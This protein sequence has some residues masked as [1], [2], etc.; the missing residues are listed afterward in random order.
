MPLLLVLMLW[1]IEHRCG[2]ES[3]L[4]SERRSV[5]SSC[6]RLRSESL[7]REDTERSGRLE[8]ERVEDGGGA[9]VGAAA[10]SG[11]TD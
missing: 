6:E 8:T 1:S 9:A 2:H 5:S 11:Q 10:G 7:A 4:A 3:R